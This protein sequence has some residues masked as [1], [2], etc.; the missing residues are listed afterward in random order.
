[1]R[2]LVGSVGGLE[3]M[4]LA[5]LVISAAVLGADLF[6]R[7]RRAR[8]P[9]HDVEPGS[10]EATS[11]YRRYVTAAASA[12]GSAREWDHRVR[13]VLAE[14]VEHA[15][16][17]NHPAGGDMREIASTWLGPRLWRTVDRTSP[18]SHDLRTPGPGPHALQEILQKMEHPNTEHGPEP[19]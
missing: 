2:E 13:P 7:F 12:S 5:G 15:I 9:Q 6:A 11:I 8:V 18:R 4:F 19:L 3:V 10:V 17:K 14:L 1:M 16:A